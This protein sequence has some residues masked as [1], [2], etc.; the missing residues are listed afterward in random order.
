MSYSL[1][2]SCALLLAH[3]LHRTQTRKGSGRPYIGHLL[4]TAGIVIEYGCTED[5]AIASLLHDA[6]ED[7]GGATTENRIREEFGDVVAAIVKDCS[8]TDQTPK[9]PWEPRKRAYLAHLRTAP[10]SVR[11]VSCADKL[12]NVRDMIAAYRVVGEA[13]WERFVKDEEGLRTPAE[14]KPKQLWLYQALADEFSREP[15]PP[16][17]AELSR[18]VRLLRDLT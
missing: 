10:A 8:D 4:S 15:S 18:Q 12:A 7:Q 6:I 9:P 5:E 3:E 16:M 2:L 13:L 17:A 1:R 14:V 11:L